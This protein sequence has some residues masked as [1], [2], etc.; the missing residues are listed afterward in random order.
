[1]AKF[2]DRG[3]YDP[4]KAAR[5]RANANQPLSKLTKQQRTPRRHGLRPLPAAPA[6][7]TDK[8]GE[9]GEST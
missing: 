8:P 5:D 3:P 7:K 9:D 1:M 4:A 2:E 6:V